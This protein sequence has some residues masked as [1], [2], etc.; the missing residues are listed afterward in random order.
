MRF[1]FFGRRDKVQPKVAGAFVSVPPRGGR[2][3]A[4]VHAGRVA[5]LAAALIDGAALEI[6]AAR[7]LRVAGGRF[8]V[9]TG[10]A[11]VL[12]TSDAVAAVNRLLVEDEAHHALAS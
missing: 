7:A 5:T 11:S 10:H 2:L 9:Q 3:V 4:E 8:L 12:I 1:G 6:G